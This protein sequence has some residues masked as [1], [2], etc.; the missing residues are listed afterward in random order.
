MYI[1]YHHDMLS[2]TELA[3]EFCMRSIFQYLKIENVA[4][5]DNTWMYLIDL[6]KESPN[7]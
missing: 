4:I 6:H 5:I 7:Y 1:V 3:V 2:H